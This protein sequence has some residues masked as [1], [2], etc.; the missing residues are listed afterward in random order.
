MLG[1]THPGDASPDKVGAKA[2]NLMR[3]ADAGLAVPPG[4]VLGTGVCVD[5]HTGG[6][7]LDQTVTTL[8]TRGV[9]HIEQ[10]TG[11]RFGADR[12]PLLVA[13]RSGAPVSMPGMLDTI[14]NVGLCDHTLPALLRTTGDPVFVWDSYRRLIQSYAEVV[15]GCPTGPFEAALDDALRRDG[16]PAVSELDVGALR[17]VVGRLQDVY[18]SAAGRPFP[19]DPMQQLLGAVEAVLRS[20]DADR[21]V[22]YRRLEGLTDLAGTAV[23]VQAMVFGNLGVTS[24]SGVGFTRDPATGENRLYVDFLLNSQGE[25]VVAGREAASDPE[26]LIAAVP[27]LAHDLLAV[28]RTLEATFGDAQDF[29]FTV[30]DGKLWLLQTRAAKRTPWAALR[31]ACDLVDEGVIDSAAAVERL[32]PYDTDRITRVRLSP[33]LDVEPIGRATPASAG[34]ASGRIALQVDSAR[35]RA[36]R[37]DP[38]VLVRDHASTEDIAA[39]AVCRGL[40]AARGARTSHAAVVARQLGVV[41]LV[42]CPDL[43][44]DLGAGRLRIGDCLFRDGDSITIDGAGGRIYAGVVPLVEDRPTELIE[45]VR[46]WQ[47]E[48]SA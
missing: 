40:L 27:G 23:T 12:R 34:V 37:G 20:W 42:N 4:F 10:E 6:G 30:E 2:A 8:V 25:D 7:H 35:R 33:D 21:A 3:M 13:V 47:R 16:V 32:R 11:L 22:E 31:I 29:E 1:V 28:R 15:E 17:D 48:L 5:Y 45:R 43:S 24:G 41:C 46:A 36:E 44:I 14:L 18:R 19:Q 9:R 39:L 38:I 26:P